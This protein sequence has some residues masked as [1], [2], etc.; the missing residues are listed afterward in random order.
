MFPYGIE[1][2]RVS[3]FRLREVEKEHAEDF[4]ASYDADYYD[5]K[6]HITF[7]NK[8]SG[9][10]VK[11]RLSFKTLETDTRL[12]L[13]EIKSDNKEPK[14]ILSSLFGGCSGHFDIMLYGK[15]RYYRDL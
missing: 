6:P 15:E 12:F 11:G 4:I 9:N 14:Y 10:I 3:Q 1:H 7:G 13:L 2:A 8:L 5:E